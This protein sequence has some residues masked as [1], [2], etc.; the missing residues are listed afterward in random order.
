MYV[1]KYNIKTMRIRPA[2]HT[3]LIDNYH[4][5]AFIQAV[6]GIRKIYKKV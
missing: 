6:I 5:W 2:Y 4:L 3:L 1:G